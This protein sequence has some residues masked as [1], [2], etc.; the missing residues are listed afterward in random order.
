MA[1]DNKK[2]K[3]LLLRGGIWHM[4]FTV[5]GHTVAETT[6]TGNLREAER[7]MAKRKAELIQDVVLEGRSVISVHKAMDEYINSRATATAKK[8]AS[9]NLSF[10]RPDKDCALKSIQKS[11][12]KAIIQQRQDE[13]K[14]IPTLNLHVRYWNAFCN[15]CVAQKY[16]EP[17][18]L[19]GFKGGAG[20][21]RWLT[22]EEEIKLLKALEVPTRYRGKSD[23]VDGRKQDNY[24]ITVMLLDTGVRFMEAASMHWNQ[25]DFE[26]NQIY[27]Q[28]SK[29][30]K[31]TVL[32]ITDRLREI[33]LR[34]RQMH[35]TLIFP[36][37]DGVNHSKH[38]MDGAVKRAGI[39]TAQGQITPHVMRHTFAVRMVQSGL[40]LHE[41]QYLLGHTHIQM[42][43]RYAHFIKQDAANK[44]AQVLNKLSAKSSANDVVTSNVVP[45]AA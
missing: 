16:H 18:K 40:Q 24:D 45:L 44:A 14:R 11:T 4:R 38:W 26:K 31:D 22:V 10:F 25:V 39:S 35:D 42:T 20:R 1:D 37:K 30:G 29:G 12:V 32:T 28:R 13:G 2:V 21:T 17:P 43:A 3:G 23:Y 7:I 27:V 34:R 15:Y 19:E 33:L 36:N 6:H 8:N 5:K 41:V 9:Y